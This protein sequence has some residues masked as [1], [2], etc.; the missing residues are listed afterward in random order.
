MGRYTLTAQRRADGTGSRDV[1]RQQILEPIVAQATAAA[2]GKEH[3]PLAQCRV[4]HPGL[5][6]CRRMLGQRDTAFLPAFAQHLDIRA[7][8]QMHIVAF[9]SGQ[10]GHTQPCLH[11][12][13]EPGVI[14]STR[15]GVVVWGRE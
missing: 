10:F 11:G 14:P 8:A 1:L 4:L 2:I 6:H 3:G 7:G 12:K 9:Q 15:P 5:Q 13:Q